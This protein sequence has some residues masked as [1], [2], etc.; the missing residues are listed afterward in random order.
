M[1]HIDSKTHTRG[2]STYVDDIPLVEGTLFGAVF[3]SPSAAGSIID[4]NIE[5]ALQ[6]PGVV[7]ILTWSDVPGVNEIGNIFPDEPLLAEGSVHYMGQPV[8]LIL[9]ETESQ[10]RAARAHIKIEIAEEKPIVDARAARVAGQLIHPPRTFQLGDTE[11][12][13]AQCAH[14]FEGRAESGGQEHLYI[15]TQGAYAIPGE[16][17]GVKLF[18]STQGPTQV[19]KATSRAL[20]L[21]MHLIE[22]DVAR[23]GGGFGG[24][25]DQ[26]T[27]WAVLAAMGA[28]STGK[29]VKLVLHRMDDMRMTGKRH[30]YDSDFKIGLAKDL[31]IVAFQVQFHQNAGAVAD[32]S[33]AV[34]ERTLFHCTN[35]YSIPNVLATAWPCRTNLPPNTA[36][37]GF[38]GPQGMFVMESAISTAAEALGVHPSV[39]QKKNLLQEGSQFPYGQKASQCHAEHCWQEAEEA[40]QLEALRSEIQAFNEK[41]PLVKK[42]YSLMPI[43]FGISFTKTALNQASALAHIYLD[44]SLGFS[45]GAV[46]MGQGVNTK[47]VQVVE[48]TLS[49]RRAK[50]KVETTNTTRAANTSPTAASAGADLNGKALEKACLALRERLLR[51]ASSLLKKP[52]DQLT[53]KNETVYCQGQASQLHWEDLVAAA[54]ERRIN[55]S[56]QSHYAT[57]TLHFNSETNRGEPFAYHVYGTAITTAS[58]DLVRGTYTVDK[59]QVVHDFGESMNP[60]IDRG[61]TEGG[62]VQGIGWMTMEEVIYNEKGRLLTNA[63]STYKVPDIYAVPKTLDIKFLKVEGHSLA[64]MKSKAVGEPPLMYGIGAYFAIRNAIRAAVPQ[65][66]MAYSAPMTPEK[67]LLALY[68]PIHQEQSQGLSEKAIN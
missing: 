32:L 19:Q 1:K 53:L 45:T 37:R 59:V 20:G 13:W 9:A 17:G 51:V 5:S 35:S 36:F 57:P 49:L 58:V 10:A 33:P 24:K 40:Y 18:S 68:G 42:G 3:D 7:A 47:L 28:L 66:P 25:E 21:P 38:G 48:K 41:S 54:W 15:E 30:P 16:Y 26:A 52:Q 23:L 27:P 31:S 44:G 63:L 14:I 4:L 11:K 29:P 62:I 67:T 2:Q 46:E 12:A 65:K 43:C 56:Q 60:V 55:L 50:I 22:V 8:A 39:I 34:L 64:I 61:Q 6:M